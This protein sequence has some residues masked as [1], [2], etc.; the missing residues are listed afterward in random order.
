M[1]LETNSERVERLLREESDKKVPG[2]TLLKGYQWNGIDVPGR[3]KA[4][5]RRLRQM[6]RRK[7]K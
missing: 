4:A 7:A 2:R 3:G 1:K 5:A 6:E